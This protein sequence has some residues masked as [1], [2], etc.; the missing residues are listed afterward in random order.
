M[1]AKGQPFQQYWSTLTALRAPKVV[2][3]SLPAHC[4][5]F[6]QI[7]GRCGEDADYQLF[8]SNFHQKLCLNNSV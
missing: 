3:N 7:G 1:L 5:P 8:L 6:L 4:V 2:E